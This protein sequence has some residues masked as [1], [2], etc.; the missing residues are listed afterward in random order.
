ML[1]KLELSSTSIFILLLLS[2]FSL[3]HWSSVQLRTVEK[4]YQGQC[5]I[6]PFYCNFIASIPMWLYLNL[7]ECTVLE[8]L[9]TLN[10]LIFIIRFFKLLS[11]YGHENYFVIIIQAVFTDLLFYRIVINCNHVQFIAI[12]IKWHA[13]LQLK[14]PQD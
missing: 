8:W 9:W 1:L 5:F 11:N 10:Y 13:A 14:T 12:C 4:V 3:F 2:C 6:E 7:D